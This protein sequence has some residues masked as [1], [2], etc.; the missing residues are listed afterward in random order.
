[1]PNIISFAVFV[2]CQGKRLTPVIP[3]LCSNPQHIRK[4]NRKCQS[5]IADKRYRRRFQLQPPLYDCSF[6]SSGVNSVDFSLRI[7]CSLA[8]AISCISVLTAEPRSYRFYGYSLFFKI[9]ISLCSRIYIL[10][11]NRHRRYFSSAA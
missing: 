8:C 3:Y 9:T 2:L 7:L 5:H 6:C 11:P 1:M 10:I 4:N